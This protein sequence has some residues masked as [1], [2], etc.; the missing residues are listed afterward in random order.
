MWPSEVYLAHGFGLMVIRDTDTEYLQI[1]PMNNIKLD[2][3]RNREILGWTL[4]AISFGVGIITIFWGHF[5]DEADNLVVGTLIVR[6][7]ALYRDVF[8]HHFPFP[9]YWM[10]MIVGFFN[11]SIFLARLSVLLFQTLTFALGMRLSGNYLLVGITAFIWSVMR[12]FYRG[13]MVLY[14]T[15]TAASLLVVFIA[16]LVLL[17]QR[18]S[19]PHW[20]HW[21][22]IG[23]FSII[24]ILSD[25]FSAYAVGIALIFLFSKKPVWGIYPGLVVLSG[26]MLFLGYMFLTGNLYAFWENA[27]LFNTQVYANYLSTETYRIRDFIKFAVTGLEITDKIW[28]EFNPFKSITGNSPELDRWLFTGFFYRFSIIISVLFLALKRQ[29]RAALFLYMFAVSTLILGKWDF[30]EQPFIM[31]SLVATSTILTKD[32][33]RSTNN[34]LLRKFQVVL[35]AMVLIL[36]VWI[37]LRLMVNIYFNNNNLGK[38]Q[39]SRIESDTMYIQDLSC[40]QSDVLLAHYPDFSYLYWFTRMNPVSKY[41]FLWPWVAD[42][43]LN[44]V[45]QDLG[46]DQILAVVVR[47]DVNVWGL[48][49]SKDYLYIL[50]EFLEMNYHKVSE[51]V[52]VSPELYSRCSK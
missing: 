43:G 44:D 51:G 36:T 15:F 40:N 48:H 22:T 27:I 21:L 3:P 42:V 52:Y 20:G 29:Y 26:L 50:D 14:H 11:E 46:Q 16:V 2:T 39:F 45:I 25:P 32:W 13:N 19:S 5:G 31:V 6:G 18:N 9:Y 1:T 10:A 34:N 8:S 7:Y 12:P 24:A 17:Q 38:I 23:L 41:L 49:D 4:L 33:W 30:R 35:G 28:F 47:E 37:C